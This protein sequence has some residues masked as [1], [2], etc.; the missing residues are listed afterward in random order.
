MLCICCGGAALFPARHPRG[1]LTTID[2][3]TPPQ[4]SRLGGFFGTTKPAADGPP[5]R[6]RTWPG[7]ALGP[8][9]VGYVWLFVSPLNTRLAKLPSIPWG[10]FYGPPPQTLG[11]L[12]GYLAKPHCAALRHTPASAPAL[13]AT[14]AAPGRSLPWG[15]WP[16][17]A[18]GPARCAAPGARYRRR[19]KPTK[20]P[21]GGARRVGVRALLGHPLQGLATAPSGGRET[22]R[23]GVS[24]L[25]LIL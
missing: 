5:P 7:V 13:A 8:P 1:R 9:H 15:R 3:A 11:P 2:C 23:Q 10:Q 12:N 14:C 22:A 20:A 16:Q 18:P 6:P 19:P 25:I 4:V 17:G 21:A 24:L